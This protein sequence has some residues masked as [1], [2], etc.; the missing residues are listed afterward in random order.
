MGVRQIQQVCP[1]GPTTNTPTFH[2][3]PGS[4][5]Y[6]AFKATYLAY[7]ASAIRSPTVTFDQRI[8]RGE[9]ELDPAE[10]LATEDIHLSTEM[11][12][13]EGVS[14]DDETVQ[15]SNL[16]HADVKPHGPCPIHPTGNHTWGECS[17][18]KANESTQR[19][20]LT[21]SPQQYY[22]EAEIN[23]NATIATGNQAELLRWHCHLG[24]L[25]F[26]ALCQLAKNGEIPKRLTKVKPPRCAGCLFGNM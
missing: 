19:G 23:N 20:T 2:T 5:N 14:A 3:A 15:I 4:F 26:P 11:G 7:D 9:H 17:L 25:P 24:H 8:L 16:S 1:I 21:F 12:G 22:D 13:D 18:N 6:Q 10:F